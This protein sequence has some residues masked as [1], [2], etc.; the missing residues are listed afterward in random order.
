M[1][2]CEVAGP[3]EE[4]G[5]GVVVKCVSF[6]DGER[7]WGGGGGEDGVC[8]TGFTERGIVVWSDDEGAGGLSASAS[9]G[10][11]VGQWDRDSAVG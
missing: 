8:E 4:K 11:C 9:M 10:V 6:S 3:L 7:G 2:V 5:G 1:V